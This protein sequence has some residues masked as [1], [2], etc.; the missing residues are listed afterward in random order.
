[1]KPSLETQRYIY[2]AKHGHSRL[3]DYCFGYHYCAR[4]GDQ[5]GDSLAGV[6][7][8]DS[9]VYIYH[10]Y[11]YTKGKSQCACPENAKLL[12]WRDFKLVQE[13]MSGYATRPPWGP[14]PDRAR[15]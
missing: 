4:C 11:L 6:Y 13:Y 3:R 5:L 14:E 2:C 8:D 9:A 15:L 7:S 1:M 12:T 10:M